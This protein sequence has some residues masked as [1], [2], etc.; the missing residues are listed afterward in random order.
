MRFR[1]GLERGEMEMVG[2]LVGEPDMLDSFERY[3]R[4]W[5]EKSG[6][7]VDDLSASPRIGPDTCCLG[8]QQKT[9]VVDKSDFHSILE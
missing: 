9:R 2:V 6:A 5:A 1:Y 4:R 3:G 7:V 8:F